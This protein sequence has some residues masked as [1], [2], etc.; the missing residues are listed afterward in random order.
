M[1]PAD[2]MALIERLV[3]HADFSDDLLDQFEGKFGEGSGRRGGRGGIG[4]GHGGVCEVFLRLLKVVSVRAEV[5]NECEKGK[6][7][8][9]GGGAGGALDEAVRR[10]YTPRRR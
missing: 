7:M 5:G 6:E 8:R 9:R 10:E 2:E 1:L 3:L 4:G